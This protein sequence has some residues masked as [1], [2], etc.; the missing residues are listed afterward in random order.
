[1]RGEERG[2][3]GNFKNLTQGLSQDLETGCPELA[4]VKNF[5]GR[6]RYTQFTPIHMYLLNEIKHTVHV[7]C[8]GIILRR[9]IFSYLLEINIFRNSSQTFWVF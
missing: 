4:I 1:M 9:K 2:Q 5:Q 7:Q 3:P 6:P 8:H